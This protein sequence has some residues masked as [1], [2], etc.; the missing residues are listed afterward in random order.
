MNIGETEVNEYPWLVRLDCDSCGVEECAGALISDR[1]VLTSAE[2]TVNHNVSHVVLGEH[3]HQLRFET[4]ELRMEVKSKIT[5]P[6][7]DQHQNDASG[8]LDVGLD[9]NLALLELQDPVNYVDYP[10]ICPICLPEALPPPRHHDFTENKGFVAGWGAIDKS[11]AK[12]SH[13]LKEVEVK[14]LSNQ[15]CERSFREQK[16]NFKVKPTVMCAKGII[17]GDDACKEDYGAPLMVSFG[18]GMTSGQNYQLAGVLSKHVCTNHFPSLYAQVATG[19]EWIN[20]EIHKAGGKKKPS[21]IPSMKKMTQQVKNLVMKVGKK[22]ILDKYKEGKFFLAKAVRLS[23]HDCIGGCN[24]CLDLTNANNA[25]LGPI[26][27]LYEELY[28]DPKHKF[29]EAI[30]RADM[31]ALLGLTMARHAAKKNNDECHLIH[32]EEGEQECKQC[33][34]SPLQSLTQA[35]ENFKWGRK[36]CPDSPV[37]NGP[38]VG[39]PSPHFNTDGNMDYWNYLGFSSQETT[40]LMGA[41]TLGA[42]HIENSGFDGPWVKDEKG[43]QMDATKQQS[44][45]LNNMYYQNMMTPDHWRA[46]KLVCG[47][48]IVSDTSVCEKKHETDNQW[49]SE[50]LGM[51]LNSDFALYKNFTVNAEGEPS[52]KTFN[53][54]PNTSTSDIVE[55]YATNNALWV[56]DFSAIFGRLINHGNFGLLMDVRK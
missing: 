24:G 11:Y 4:K 45:W 6:S 10:H 1:H 32:C 21:G 52:C 7:F 28:M 46:G 44:Q 15:E 23:F 9:N 49:N 39:L 14:I 47:P 36:D 22:A 30:S 16:P 20:D 17:Q 8:G 5:N 33:P 26:R 38:H 31:W 54:C 43:R 56:K 34:H 25:G 50:E 55:K 40:A 13:F 51:M 37:Y 42:T 18:D 41:H 48:D 3:N 19:L 2:C 35:I 12:K 27:D 53:E 29:H